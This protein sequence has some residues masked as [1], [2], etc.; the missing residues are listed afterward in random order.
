MSQW[1]F[2]AYKFYIHSHP[3]LSAIDLMLAV[4]GI[5]NSRTFTGVNMKLIIGLLTFT[6]SAFALASGGE[7]KTFVYDGSQ[8]SVE[9]LLS[10][11]KTH[12]EYRVEQ[13]RSICYRTEYH[14]RTACTGG[15]HRGPRHCHTETFPRTV[16]YP[17]IETVRIP[18]EVHD[19]YT[20]AKVVLNVKNLSNEAT[21]GERF[22]VSLHGDSV[23]LAVEG[24]K[25]F[26]IMQKKFP[27]SSS[28]NG[29]VR[30]HEGEATVE[31]IEAAPVLKALSMTSISISNDM[32]N[33]EMGPVAA[34][35]FLGFSLYVAKKIVFGSDEV[36]FNR[37]L[38]LNE[39]QLKP[40]T[41]GSDLSIDVKKLGLELSGAKFGITA[42]TFF[43]AQG[44]LLNSSEFPATEASRTLI[45]TNR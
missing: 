22:R 18:Y 42:K 35:D 19:Y 3:L 43:K 17:C 13:R 34:T 31:L 45:Y 1:P 15:G 30:H 41:A 10:G 26:F 20:S 16:A 21:P 33:V 14:H 6:L 36:L 32:L 23:S 38:A 40:T 37:E 44:K 7:T 39:L 9:L 2:G 8:S 11:E 25:K 24:S 12:T 4:D 28:W 5:R 29:S 27:L